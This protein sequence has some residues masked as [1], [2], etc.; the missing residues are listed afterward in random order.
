MSDNNKEP[1]EIH[2]SS[3]GTPCPKRNKAFNSKSRLKYTRKEQQEFADYYGVSSLTSVRKYLHAG[4][5]LDEFD[6]IREHQDKKH[7]LNSDEDVVEAKKRKIKADAD[8]AE[9]KAKAEQR[10]LEILQG[11]YILLA[12]AER[13]FIKLS[14]I[15]KARV[16]AFPST[17]ATSLA[18]KSA[19]GCKKT[20]KENVTQLII[21]L[22]RITLEQ[23]D[24]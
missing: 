17:L 15:L 6:A 11:K 4:F 23:D 13:A 14:S 1:I 9:T 24:E 8:I 7:G 12:D 21:E 16:E 20:L 18:G 2:L 5:N 22:N 19:A 3:L 10:K